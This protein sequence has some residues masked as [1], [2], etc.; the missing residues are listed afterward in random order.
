LMIQL[1]FTRMYLIIKFNQLYF[2]NFI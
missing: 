1:V 2:Y